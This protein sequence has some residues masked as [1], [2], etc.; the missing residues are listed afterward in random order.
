[1]RAKDFQASLISYLAGLE[2][3][4]ISPQT[5]RFWFEKNSLPTRHPAFLFIQGYLHEVI[6]YDALTNDQK[7]V[8]RQIEAFLRE[9]LVSRAVSSSP[10]K[11]YSSSK[12][13]VVID[14]GDAGRELV[15]ANADRL[16][17]TY[18]TYRIRL[19]ESESKPIAQEVI[20]IFRRKND[21]RFEHWYLR[22]G[23]AIAK[24]EGLV[25]GVDNILWFF[26]ASSVSP[27]RLRVMNFRL[28]S[29]SG[30]KYSQLRWGLMLSDVSIPSSRDPA[31]CRIVFLKALD[32]EVRTL[33]NFVKENVMYVSQ[34]E[35]KSKNKEVIARL[36]DN[37]VTAISGYRSTA[38]ITADDKR[39]IRDMILKVNQSTLDAALDKLG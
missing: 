3:P 29:T 21:V 9:A 35:I 27:E 10:D 33:S 36:V 30:T 17:G 23:T 8:F 34:E 12:G 38:P 4:P 6:G 18:R 13:R 7:K 15:R 14:L 2:Q 19:S 31:A 16:V 20:R 32:N 28:I 39:P 1:M 5:I 24:F 37:T 22:E 11:I 26:G 25:T